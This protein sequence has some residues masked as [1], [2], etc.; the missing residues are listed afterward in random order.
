MESED[1]SSKISRALTII[2]LIHIV[3][4]GLIFIHQRFLDGRTEG[5]FR[6]LATAPDAYPAD[7]TAPAPQR[8]AALSSGEKP[9]TSSAPATTMRASPPP[10]VWTR[11]NSASST[12]STSARAD[13]QDPAQAHRRRGSAGSHRDPRSRTAFRPG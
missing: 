8:P 1:G 4:I 12:T 3:A 7:A 11:A 2:F 10:K 9:R 13:P 6:R 5:R